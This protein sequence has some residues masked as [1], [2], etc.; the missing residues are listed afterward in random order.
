MYIS[1][2]LQKD[3]EI[4]IEAFKNGITDLKLF[5]IFDDKEFVLYALKNKNLSL[6]YVSKDLLNDKEV[7]LESIKYDLKNFEFA[8]FQVKNEREVIIKAIDNNKES[9]TFFSEFIKKYFDNDKEIILKMMKKYHYR[10]LPSVS[11]ILKN[12]KEIVLEGIKN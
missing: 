3:K 8:S 12:D 5:N 11:K 10:F 6:K 1:D 7:V 9:T 4:A 2:E